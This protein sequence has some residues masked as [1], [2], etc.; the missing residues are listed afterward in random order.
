MNSEMTYYCTVA[1]REAGLGNHKGI[2]SCRCRN[3]YPSF[4]YL[5][6]EWD[7]S[8]ECQSPYDR[9]T[10]YMLLSCSQIPLPSSKETVL[11]PKSLT[12]KVLTEVVHSVPISALKY[13]A[14]FFSQLYSSLSSVAKEIFLEEI[15]IYISLIL[16]PAVCYFQD[17]DSN[18]Y[19]WV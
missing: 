3:L 4:I 6:N 15:Y 19:S 18:S 17:K 16:W 2:Y 12:G 7:V 8:V 13:C 1:T 14:S 10:L 9:R 11:M 5:M